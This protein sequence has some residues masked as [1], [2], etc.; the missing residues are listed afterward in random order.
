MALTAFLFTACKKD[1][2]VPA[3]LTRRTS[4][5]LSGAAETPAIPSTGTGRIDVA[6]DPGSK[7][8]SYTLSWQLGSSAATTAAMHFHGAEDGSDLKSSAVTIGVTGFST[9]SSGTLSGATRALTQAE[10]DQLLAGKWYFNVHSS[11]NPGGE[12]RGNLK[13]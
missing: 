10:E 3:D 6:Y 8:I 11:T 7:I 2:N 12:L 4:A 1:N 13:F 9:G 5:T